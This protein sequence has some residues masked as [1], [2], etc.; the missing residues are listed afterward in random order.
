MNKNTKNNEKY[1][2]ILDAAVKIFAEQGFHNSTISQIAREAGV[3]D[4][5]IYLYF[6][7]KQD[8]LFQFFAYKTRLVFDHFKEAV[9]KESNA[10]D[11]L[12]CL[13][14]IHFEE[15]QR[16]RNMAEVYR[17]ETRQSHRQ[18]E[19]QIKE[20]TKMYLDLISSIVEQGQEEATMRQD[21]FLALVKRFILGAVEE[22]IN[23]WVISGGK[24]DLLSQADPLVDLFLKGIGAQNNQEHT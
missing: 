3:A 9:D 4:G 6:K 10:I 2:R 21:I 23:V 13:I 12:R 24:Y 18:M 15:F 20:M 11:K 1:H 19:S 8:I 16:D 7:N 5:T 17:M 14:R 22:V